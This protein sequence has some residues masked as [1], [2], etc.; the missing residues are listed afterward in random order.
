MRWM[1]QGPYEALYSLF[2]RH[3]SYGSQMPF[4]LPASLRTH[5]HRTTAGREEAVLILGAVVA[6][7]QDSPNAHD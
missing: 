3:Q 1:A 7:W 4:I 2:F 6:S 5:K